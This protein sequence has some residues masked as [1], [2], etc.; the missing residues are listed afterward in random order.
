MTF[1]EHL[2]E[3]RNLILR[4][5]TIFAIC[6]LIVVFFFPFFSDVLNYPL[7]KIMN[8]NPDVIHGLVTNSPTGVFSVLLRICFIGGVVVSMPF[9]LYLII[10]FVN[11]GLILNEKIFTTIIIF[12]SILLFVTGALLSYLVIIPLSLI[13]SIKLNYL[14]GFQ[15]IWSAIH[16]YNLVLWM[17]FGVGICFEFPL[18]ILFMI[19]INFIQLP[20]LVK[21]RR[22]VIVFILTI[23]AII[24][25]GGDPFLL[26]FLSIPIYS[27]YEITILICIFFQQNDQY[28]VL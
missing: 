22:Y 28:K 7:Q 4:C 16:Y 17:I 9:L 20:E 13:I 6:L 8:S 23:S 18:I 25:P 12:T 2:E 24:T 21:L 26:I 5:M 1:L 14:F 10:R 11:P 19:R 15:L 27:L 3:F